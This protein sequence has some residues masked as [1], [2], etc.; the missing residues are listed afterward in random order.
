MVAGVPLALGYSLHALRGAADR[1]LSTTALFLCAVEAV[2]LAGL[3]LAAATR[4]WR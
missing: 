4:V 3:V 1:T 2:A